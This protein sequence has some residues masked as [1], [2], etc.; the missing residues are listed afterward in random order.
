MRYILCTV[1]KKRNYQA[2]RYANHIHTRT[3]MD[4][5]RKCSIQ[6]WRIEKKKKKSDR[7]HS[8]FPYETEGKKISLS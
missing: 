1:C 3:H 4:R 2:T 8:P 6:I 7:K 5:E